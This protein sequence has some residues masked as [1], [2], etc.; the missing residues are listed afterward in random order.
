MALTMGLRTLLL[1]QTSI[2]TLAPTQIVGGITLPAVMCD[3]TNQGM[4]PPWVIV[5]SDDEDDPVATLDGTICEDISI[6]SVAFSE[7]AARALNAAVKSYLE[8]FVGTATAAGVT[9]TIQG[10]FWQDQNYSYDYPPDGGDT[11]F[12]KVTSKYQVYYLSG[13]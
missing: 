2:T 5:N 6:D 9:D 8:P 4:K 1:A 7:Q 3:N 10:V 12:H 11:K 13:S